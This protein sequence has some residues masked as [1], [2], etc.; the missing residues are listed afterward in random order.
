MASFVLRE[1][2]TSVINVFFFFSQG[3]CGGPHFLGGFYIFQSVPSACSC[4]QIIIR[5]ACVALLNQ[6]GKCNNNLIVRDALVLSS[7]SSWS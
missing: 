3:L 2:K 7:D 1:T 5:G 6:K 4:A